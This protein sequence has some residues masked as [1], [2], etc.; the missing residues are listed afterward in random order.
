MSSPSKRALERAELVAAVELVLGHG[1]AE[2]EDGA[3]EEGCGAC[4]WLK[5]P[6]T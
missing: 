1:L 3:E 5:H 4:A 2:E 6:A